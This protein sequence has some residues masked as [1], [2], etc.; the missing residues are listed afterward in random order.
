MGIQSPLTAIVLVISVA[1]ATAA[2]LV[3]WNRLRAPGW[4]RVATRLL[5]LIVCQALAVLSVAV[6]INDHYR[7]YA[8]WGELVGQSNVR[9]VSP[10]LAQPKIDK[11]YAKQ[12][13]RSFARHAGLVIPW[14]IPGTSSGLPNLPALAYLPPEYGNPAAPD[15]RF[16]VVELLDG[17][18]GTPQTWLSGMHL[19]TVLDTAIR[20]G[21]I[22]PFIAIMPT[23]NVR[24]PHDT[25]CLNVVGGPAV[26][27]YLTADVHSAVLANFRAQDGPASW[28]L[29]GYSTGGYCAVNLA[30]QR[31]DLY[32]AAASLSGYARPD[33]GP[34]S[35][36]NLLHG[37]PVL[38]ELNTPLWEEAHWGCQPLAILAAASH[39]DGPSLR[40]TEKLIAGARPPLRITPLILDR[41]GH[42]INLW[43][44]L[45]PVM[46]SWLSSHLT[47][48]LAPVQVRG[49]LGA[50]TR[51]ES[52][53]V[54]SSGCR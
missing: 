14:S 53:P 54:P 25:Q 39:Q 16:P 49:D 46:F 29:A 45:E 18:P 50:E 15:Q 36:H 2:T 3:F 24:A 1:A 21:H 34:P 19:R 4:A 35:P 41:G 5:A 52:L 38:T 26:S 23:Q 30:M 42:T 22:A 20:T 8:S 13:R 12:L 27:T 17:V 44:A 47:P 51:V 32:G 40:D 28:A 37:D 48:A 7:L 11:R 31:P 43:R 33:I 9:A 6:L 10:T